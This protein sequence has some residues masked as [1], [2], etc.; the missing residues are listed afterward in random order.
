LFKRKEEIH[1]EHIR[2]RAEERKEIERQA[3]LEIERQ[4]QEE[5]RRLFQKMERRR[6]A[7]K[8][9]FCLL[10]GD[11]K[12][13]D[14]EWSSVQQQPT[15]VTD[16]NY[17]C[18]HYVNGKVQSLQ[19][20]EVMKEVPLKTPVNEEPKPP[21]PH[22][23]VKTQHIPPT[24]KPQKKGPEIQRQVIEWKTEDASISPKPKPYEPQQQQQ[25]TGRARFDR[26]EKTNPSKALPG[27]PP[28]PP[29]QVKESSKKAEMT[30]NVSQVLNPIQFAQ[31]LRILQSRLNLYGLLIT[32]EAWV[33]L[34][35]EK[36][37]EANEPW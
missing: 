18:F 33:C 10:K 7:A 8:A 23:I 14:P 11:L 19:E 27:R 31:L 36:R 25:Q 12:S 20:K 1:R 9:N 2:Q 6:A 21:N 16:S 17:N 37:F 32:G 28:V 34:R 26:L 15:R 5:Y 30:H 29:L 22:H 13:D 35:L 3:L 24:L 4:K